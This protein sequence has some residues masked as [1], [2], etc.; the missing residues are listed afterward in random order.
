MEAKE[1]MIGDWVYYGT[2][3]SNMGGDYDV[4]FEAKQ[5]TINDFK[6]FADNDWNDNDFEEFLQPIPLTQEILEKNGACHSNNDRLYMC[7]RLFEY[8]EREKM[9]HVGHMNDS[10]ESPQFD[11]HLKIKYVHE[12]QHALRLWGID[13]EIE[14]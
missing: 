12:F 10:Y 6:F 1:L 14:L 13:K 5:L 8:N 11:I 9:W 4:V 2:C 3:K 7:N